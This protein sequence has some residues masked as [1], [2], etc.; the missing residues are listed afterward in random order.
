[1]DYQPILMSD[2]T[3]YEKRLKGCYLAKFMRDMLD[4]DEFF[5]MVKVNKVQAKFLDKYF[6][7]KGDEKLDFNPENIK[8]EKVM[9]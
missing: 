2:K 1:M 5:K 6:G 8:T 7:Y 9:L 4:G 3:R